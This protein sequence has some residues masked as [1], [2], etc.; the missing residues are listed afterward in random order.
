MVITLVETMAARVATA[1]P[2]LRGAGALRIADEGRWALDALQTA[3]GLAQHRLEVLAAALAA[4]G[5]VISEL[6][7]G[8]LWPPNVLVNGASWYVLDLEL[9]GRVRVPLYDLLHMLHVCSDVRR[10]EAAGHRPWVE[11]LLADPAEAGARQLI[12]HSAQRRG[13]SPASTF[14][15]LVYY[16]VDVTARI[17][18][19]GAWT[20]D[21][22]EYFAQAERLA[23]LIAEGVATPERLLTTD[24][25]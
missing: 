4:G 15:A 25:V 22:R 9:F 14:A 16:L 11:L 23:D 5:E 21:W 12:R 3:H 7:H 24:R 18:A 6:Q 13:L 19:R 8:D 10:P 2:T 17:R 20:A 1:M